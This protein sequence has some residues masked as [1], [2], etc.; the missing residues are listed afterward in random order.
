VANI[1]AIT[2]DEVKNFHKT[3][4]GA[5]NATMSIVG[6]FDANEIKGL[7]TDLF[8]NW[9]S[10]QPYTRLVSKAAAVQQINEQFETPDKANAFFAAA[11]NFE[12][13]DDNPDYPALVLGNYMLGGGFLNSRLATRIRQKEGLSYGVGSQFNAG[14]LDPVGSFFAYAIYAPENAEKLEAA[15]KEEIQKVITEGF[16]AEEIA[17]AKSGWTQ[18]RTVTRSQ[19]G[20]LAGTLNNYL[21]IKR[22]LSWDKALEAKVMALTPDQINAAMKKHITPEKISIIKAG[23]FAKAKKAKENK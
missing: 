10:L 16:T 8:G 2:L 12:M 15:F 3:F 19:D 4:Y 22:D 18:S 21:F 5:S 7:V 6:D 11:Y 17:A 9:K 1:K 23:D 20:S 13:K 14:A